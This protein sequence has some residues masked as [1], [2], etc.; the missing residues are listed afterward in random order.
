MKVKGYNMKIDMKA[1]MKNIFKIIVKLLV[2]V[3]PFIIAIF[4]FGFSSQNAEQS[5][6]L[7]SK[8]A[9]AIIHFANNSHILNVKFENESQFIEN[10]QYPI[11]KCAH[12]SEYMIFTLSVVLAL[13]VWNVKNKWLYIIAFAISVIFAST[14]EIHQL[15]V[16]G[17]SG[18]AVD[19]LIDSIGATIGLLIVW[20]VRKNR[21]KTKKIAK[22]NTIKVK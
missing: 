4:I 5:S 12:M 14:D 10:M 17:R 1:N 16:P 7:S 6:G 2:W 9:T 8:A 21:N 15:F 22:T 13:Y 19:V 11:R 18:R 20:G 3:P